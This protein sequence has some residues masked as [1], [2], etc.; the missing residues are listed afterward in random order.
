VAQP[1]SD[2]IVSFASPPVVE[3]VAGVAFDGLTPETSALLGAFWKEQLRQEFPT[4][5][6]QPPITTQDEQFPVGGRSI[7]AFNA[8]AGM[9]APRLWAQSSDGQDLLQLQPG[10]FACNWRKVQPDGEYDRWARRRGDFQRYF[11]R[12]IE[13]LSKEGAGQPKIRQCEVT[14][15][16][17]I[18]ASKIWSS[19][20]EFSKIFNVSISSDLPQLLEQVTFQGQF[21]LERDGEPYGRLYVKII[22]AFGQD[23]KTPLYV[24]ELTAR[25]A[26]KAD[27]VEGA[28]AFL[29]LGREAIDLTFVKLTSDA[30]HREWGLQR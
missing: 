13:Y 16:N 29:D 25:G 23:G 21:V 10:W 6:L 8:L 28:L 18:V 27:G 11:N 9:P 30:M 4:L 17:H 24:L 12:L 7:F 19:H 14:Y 22:P 2:S 20:A 5:Q 26:P 3:V 1:V 15:I